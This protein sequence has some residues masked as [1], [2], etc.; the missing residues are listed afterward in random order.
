[1]ALDV[2]L[3]GANVDSAGNLKVALDKTDA[4]LSGYARPLSEVDAGRSTGTAV[5]IAGE[6]SE[7]F[8]T[9]VELDTLLDSYTFNDALQN[10]AK[11]L[12]RNLTMTLSWAG[13]FINSNA[14]SIITLNTGV[15]FQTDQYFPITGG[16]ETY[17]YFKLKVTG[18]WA[19]TN[20]TIDVGFLGIPATSTPY[21]PTDGAWIRLNSTGMFGVVSVNGTEQTTPVFIDPATALA[22]VPIIGTV[23]NC[24][25]TMGENIAVFWIDFRDG[26]GYTMVGRQITAAGSG[27]PLL[28]GSVQFGFRHAIGGVSASGV[29][30][31]GISSYLVSQGGFSF[32]RPYASVAAMMGASG[33]Q[34]QSGHASLGSTALYSNSLAAGAG[35]VASNTTAAGIGLGGQISIQPTLAVP[36][37]GIVCSY[38][39]P[40]ASNIIT[41]RQLI[42]TGIIIQGMVTTALTGGP[43]L[44]AMS[45]AWGQ[46]GTSMVTAESAAGKAPR[47][48]PLGFQKFVVTAPVGDISEHIYI[49][50]DDIVVNPG[51]SFAIVAK[52]L[53]TVTSAGVITFLIGIN[54][55]WA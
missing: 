29:M 37:D 39:N 35:A 3:G 10:T 24:I 49:P 22:F 12:T 33:A 8:R 13:G 54:A 42:V 31:I 1:M 6:V 55:H 20:T 45:A 36:T 5:L 25:V 11:H 14:S 4:L 41:G 47:R 2:L 23:Y 27:R 17:A 46:T 53:G 43:V 28:S 16:A 51:E 44:Y 32:N 19:V 52:N 48:K 26:N 40:V 9:R 34:G 7:D 18:T 15:M 30:A 21:A 38:L 50:I